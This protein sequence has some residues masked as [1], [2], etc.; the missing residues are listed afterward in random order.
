[1]LMMSISFNIA[2]VITLVANHFVEMEEAHTLAIEHNKKY[3]LHQVD[4]DNLD[5]KTILALK[6]PCHVWDWR[7]QTKCAY[8]R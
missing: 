7:E 3:S 4:P 6:D 8:C 2:V 1:M 5:R